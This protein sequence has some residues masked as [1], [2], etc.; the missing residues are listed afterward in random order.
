MWSWKGADYSPG[1][2]GPRVNSSRHALGKIR[3][4]NPN[5][6]TPIKITTKFVKELGAW[7]EVVKKWLPFRTSRNI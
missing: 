2:G 3:D 1:L 4:H 6:K 7:M 5:P